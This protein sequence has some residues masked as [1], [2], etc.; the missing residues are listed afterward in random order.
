ML[1]MP[2]T[3]PGSRPNPPLVPLNLTTITHRLMSGRY[4]LPSMAHTLDC[5]FEYVAVV[6]YDKGDQ[7]Y[8]T[9]HGKLQVE[10]WFLDK[11]QGP[12]SERGLTVRLDLVQVLHRFHKI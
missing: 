7:F 10:Q 6:G 12:L 8:D 2:S 4:L 3:P 11:I 5:G 1:P 9:L